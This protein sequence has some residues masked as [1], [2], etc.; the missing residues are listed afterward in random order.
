MNGRLLQSGSSVYLPS[1]KQELFEAAVQKLTEQYTC[2]D[3]SVTAL[4]EQAEMSEVHFRRCFKQIYHV[5]PQQYLIELRLTKARELLQ[6]DT[7]PIAEVAMISG[8]SDACYFSR[9]FKKKTG[10]SPFEYRV[11]FGTPHPD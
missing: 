4:A 5:S 7:T 2:E 3:F 6:Y 11:K 9:L 10:Y 8:F 1:R